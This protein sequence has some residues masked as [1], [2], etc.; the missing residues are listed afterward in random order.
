MR[1]IDLSALRVNSLDTTV[2]RRSAN[3]L[4]GARLRLKQCNG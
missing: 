4:R 2:I 3:G 1:I